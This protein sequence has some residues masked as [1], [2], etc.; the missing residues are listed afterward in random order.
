MIYP[1]ATKTGGVSAGLTKEK[2]Q[3]RKAISKLSMGSFITENA[4]GYMKT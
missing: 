1:M 3:P 4:P 2:R